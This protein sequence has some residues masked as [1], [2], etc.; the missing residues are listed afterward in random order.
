M[1]SPL[2]GQTQAPGTL[3]GAPAVGRVYDAILDARFD[4]VAGLLTEACPPA[5]RE[6]CQLLDVV[7]LWWRIQLDP[8]NTSHDAEFQAKADAAIA[9]V[10]AWTR[11]EP[12]RA[13]A[14]FYLGGA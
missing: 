13:E 1:V 7:A 12:Q 8:G 3:T 6:V 14:W 2:H 5:P 9:A 10:E 4:D 11:T